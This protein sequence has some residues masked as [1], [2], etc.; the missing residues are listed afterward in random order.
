MPSCRVQQTR[1]KYQILK[2]FQDDSTRNLHDISRAR[3][4][5]KSS[6]DAKTRM[7]L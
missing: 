2:L 1:H 3:M 7:I 5:P 4:I 6:M